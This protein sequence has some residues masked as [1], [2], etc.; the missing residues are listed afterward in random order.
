MLAPPSGG[1]TFCLNLLRYQ[2]RSLM[3]TADNKLFKYI[4]SKLNKLDHIYYY[5][6]QGVKIPLSRR[7]MLT[8]Q[9]QLAKEANCSRKTVLCFIKKYSDKL[10][11]TR[12]VY[13]QHNRAIGTVFS[14]KSGDNENIP[15]L[16]ALEELSDSLGYNKSNTSLKIKQQVAFLEKGLELE[17]QNKDYWKQQ[18]LEAW[19]QIKE[20]RQSF[21]QT[22]EGRVEARIKAYKAKLASTEK[23]TEFT[24]SSQDQ[25]NWDKLNQHL[26]QSIFKDLN[27]IDRQTLWCRGKKDVNRIIQCIEYT[28]YVSSKRTITNPKSYLF[29]ALIRKWD[30]AST[31]EE[32]YAQRRQEM[33]QDDL[34]EQQAKRKEQ[35]YE[36]KKQQAQKKQLENKQIISWLGQ[37]DRTEQIQALLDPSQQ[38]IQNLVCQQA[39]IKSGEL[40]EFLSSEKGLKYYS[41]LGL[42]SRIIQLVQSDFTQKDLI[43]VRKATR[44]GQSAE[45]QTTVGIFNSYTYGNR[46]CPGKELVKSS[47]LQT[48][49]IKIEA[50][51]MSRLG[52]CFTKVQ[53]IVNH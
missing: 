52:D 47:R 29:K 19:Q 22:V 5:S 28:H 31:I 43:L 41:F 14:F 44:R 37:G 30:L 46:V 39:K 4:C 10:F 25:P 18:T 11:K 50:R 45:D 7:E 21:N 24:I 38:I 27:Q 26:D 17:K 48:P 15:N 13:N 32:I 23:K 8:T 9:A 2:I 6:K 34:R 53:Q 49:T 20:L 42:R 35:E 12:V 40:A 1:N 3:T 36:L 16:K 51:D 33:E